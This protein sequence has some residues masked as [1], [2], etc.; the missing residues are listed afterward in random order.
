MYNC[1]GKKTEGAGSPSISAGK[2]Q[3]KRLPTSKYYFIFTR[4]KV[5]LLALIPVALNL[6]IFLWKPKVEMLASEIRHQNILRAPCSTG[7]RS[8]Q[9]DWSWL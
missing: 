2:E 4:T 1:G 3:P 7:E 6:C 9:S 8:T 5:Y